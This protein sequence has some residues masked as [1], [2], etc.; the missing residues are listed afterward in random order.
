MF[1]PRP[2]VRPSMEVKKFVCLKHVL[3]GFEKGGVFL[4]FSIFV[5]ARVR[6]LRSMC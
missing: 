6:A 2:S 1:L 4:T 3:W 5:R